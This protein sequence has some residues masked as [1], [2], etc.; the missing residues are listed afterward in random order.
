MFSAL[1]ILFTK[2]CVF[3]YLFPVCM[4]FIL[5]YFI[6]VMTLC[7]MLKI[8]SERRYPCLVP[9]FTRKA[10]SFSLSSRMLPIVCFIFLIISLYQV[11]KVSLFPSL[12]TGFVKNGYW[13]LSNASVA[14]T[15]MI[16]RYVFRLL[17]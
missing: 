3:I 9:N 16:I 1:I 14:S 7:M 6:L 12:L 4:P 8:S 2:K 11:E 15:Y 5:S 13:I 17:M 10:S